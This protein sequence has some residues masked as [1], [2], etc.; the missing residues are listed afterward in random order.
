MYDKKIA[1]LSGQPFSFVSKKHPRVSPPPGL[2]AQPSMAA[3]RK[4]TGAYPPSPRRK[5]QQSHSLVYPETRRLPLLYN[6]PHLSANTWS[7]QET[8]VHLP[9]SADPHQACQVAGSKTN[10]QVPSP[11]E[12]SD[13]GRPIA[14]Y[15]HRPNLSRLFG[16]NLE[17][18]IYFCEIVH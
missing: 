2:P 18:I 1:H 4:I 15:I 5:R 6:L 10:S 17:I 8:T 3:P 11:G 16:P 7:L 9:P 12:A 14:F 13:A